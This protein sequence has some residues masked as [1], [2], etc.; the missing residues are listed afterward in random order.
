MHHKLM[1]ENIGNYPISRPFAPIYRQLPRIRSQSSFFPSSILSSIS[2]ESVYRLWQ[3]D[4]TA[5][6][7]FLNH[8][9]FNRKIFFHS[10]WLV[11]V[12]S[13]SISIIFRSTNEVRSYET[14]LIQ[15]CNKNR[16]HLTMIIMNFFEQINFI[17][18]PYWPSS[19]DSRVEMSPSRLRLQSCLCTL[20]NVWTLELQNCS[21]T[22]SLSLSFGR[23]ISFDLILFHL[24]IAISNWQLAISNQRRGL[25]IDHWRDE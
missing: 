11:A 8:F 13:Y 9:S 2:Y 21:L 18:K 4:Y 12:V 3:A 25:I 10:Q 19:Y 6:S 5:V 7:P 17:I 20:I 14:S 1:N 23:W 16:Q 24:I 22:H 15:T